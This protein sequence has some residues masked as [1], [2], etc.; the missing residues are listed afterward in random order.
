MSLL[1]AFN[2]LH[3][4]KAIIRSPINYPGN[5]ME[6]MDFTLSHL[7]K[8]D[9][10]IDAFGGSGQ[11][12]LC[13]EPCRL[14]VYNDL[15]NGISSFYRVLQDKD[16]TK[17]LID[18][19]SLFIHSREMFETFKTEWREETDLV[20]KAVKF[21]Y[22][23]QAS[24]LSRG[25][26]YGRV[27]RGPADIYRK[28][29]RYLPLFPTVHNRFH[30]VQVENL[31]FRE[32]IRIYDSHDAVFYCDPPYWDNNQ[33]QCLMSR[34]EHLELCKLIFQSKGFFAVA[35]YRNEIYDQFP[36]DRVEMTVIRQQSGAVTGDPTN[37]KVQSR[38][39]VR[40]EY[41]FIKEMS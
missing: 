6:I 38:T 22:I 24:H 28:L 8:T 26:I 31:H 23:I 16:L 19:V 14:E 34:A 9:K 35:G 41:L 40:T 39:D 4:E 20:S 27:T 2:N 7:P 13:R 21:Y 36:W 11:V 33:Y 3:G 1:D 32:L 12:M 18:R 25:R 10:F 30:K 5:K 37:R 15:D 29:E 17:Q